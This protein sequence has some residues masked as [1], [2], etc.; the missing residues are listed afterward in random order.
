MALRECG[1]FLAGNLYPK[2][3]SSPIKIIDQIVQEEFGR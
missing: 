3:Y 2:E 1:T